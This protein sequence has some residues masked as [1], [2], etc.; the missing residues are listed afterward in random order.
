M[1]L[2]SASSRTLLSS[3]SREPMRMAMW[4]MPL[5]PA[6]KRKWR[7]SGRNHGERLVFSPRAASSFEAGIVA[8]PA[9][10]TRIRALVLSGAKTMTPWGL[11]EP[12]RGGNASAKV[13]GVPPAG[14]I[15]L[16]LPSAANALEQLS[17]DQNA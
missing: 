13:S 7:P 10:A 15:L 1:A 17:G 16:S 8:P 11:Q 4:S 9:A 2:E 3:E 14:S 5:E 6:E 12:P